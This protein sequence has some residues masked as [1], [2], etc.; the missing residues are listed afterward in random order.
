METIRSRHLRRLPEKLVSEHETRYSTSPEGM[1]AFLDVFFARHFFQIQDSLMEHFASTEFS[2]LLERDTLLVLDIGS[3]PAVAALAFTDIL[4]CMFR[5]K[6]MKTTF[7]KILKVHYVLNDTSSICLAT[8]EI[9]L[10]DYFQS[11]LRD[12]CVAPG[13]RMSITK[14][15]PPNLVQLRRISRHFGGYDIVNLSYV[16]TPLIEA[17][18][19]RDM[20]NGLF[21]LA[22]LSAPGAGL[23]I[24]QDRFSG[25]SIRRTNSVLGGSCFKEKL[26]QQVYSTRN[27]NTSYEY[28][29][30]RCM[31]M[32]AKGKNVSE[33]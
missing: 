20:V 28:S 10:R 22:K 4:A 16:L 11:A 24:L 7:G 3:G 5:Q 18:G 19:F 8:G 6:V 23:L 31:W 26:S 21:N 32:P 2:G 14:P 25:P 15:F 33:L 9:M 29:Y 17:Y 1:H 30:Y 13:I 27:S 12:S